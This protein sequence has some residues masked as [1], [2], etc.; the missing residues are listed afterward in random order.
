VSDNEKERKKKGTSLR[1]IRVEGVPT[2]LGIESNSCA[3]KVT[4]YT[5]NLR[6][7]RVHSANKQQLFFERR[8][9]RER[10]EREKE[11]R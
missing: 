9:Q 4:M 11:M 1:K 10:E 3:T 7:L 6:T 8:E 5:T 2:H